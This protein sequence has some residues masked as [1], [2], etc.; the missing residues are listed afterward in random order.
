MMVRLFAFLAG[1]VFLFAL[2]FSIATTPLKNEPNAMHSFVKH[3]RHVAL[4]SDGVF[5]KF[6]QGQLQRGLKV[7]KE[8]CS[9]CHGLG[10]VAIRNIAELGY[11]ESQVKAFAKTLTVPS[12]NPETG[13]P[14]TRP[15]LPSDQFPSPYA[16]DVAARAANNGAVP[17]DLSLITKAREGGKDYVYSLL[18]GYQN[19]P[20]NLPKELKPT[21]VLHY[22]PYFPNLNLA[23]APPLAEGQVTFDDGTKSTV[24]QMAKD[25][26]A[27]LVWTAE[28]NL[29]ARHAGGWATI[30]FLLMFTTLAYLSYRAVWADKK[31]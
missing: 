28:P 11:D 4:S 25:V 9:S 8:V 30:I 29:Q 2:A 20:A 5:G 6:D 18:T 24:D 10:Q 19:P 31:H 23:M 12:I 13:E 1:L 22:N 3:P 21:G 17:P 15:G 27:F 26:S 16:N 14:A 7:Y